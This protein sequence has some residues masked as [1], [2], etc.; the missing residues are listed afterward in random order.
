[1]KKLKKNCLS[2]IFT[3]MALV[4]LFF[5]V[6]SLIAADGVQLEKMRDQIKAKGWTFEI[7]I[8]P[9]VNYANLNKLY[10]GEPNKIRLAAL[11]TQAE[12][13]SDVKLPRVYSCISTPVVNQGTCNAWPFASNAMFESVILLKDNDTV[14]LSENW[15]LEC[16]PYGWDCSDGW[17]ASDIFFHYGAVLASDFPVG[18]DCNGVTISYQASSWR[19]CG[20]GYSVASNDSIKQAIV[21]YGSVACLVYV[22]SYFQ[23]YASG[24]FNSSAEG[25]VNHFVTI[26]GWDDTKGAWRIKNSWGPGWGESGYM[27]IAYGCHNIGWAANYLIFNGS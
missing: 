8:S 16:N 12:V 10:N 2:V 23:F 14:R 22:D 1:M 21:D 15:L 18:T 19:F 17:F 4:S 5:M 27:W 7:G 20:N 13:I 9:D 11:E 6:H 24:V 26:C 3:A 25:D